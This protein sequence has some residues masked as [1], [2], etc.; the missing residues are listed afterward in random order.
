MDLFICKFLLTQDAMSFCEGRAAT[1]M[2]RLG[3]ELKLADKDVS[4]SFK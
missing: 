2:E 4:G 3:L 1:Q